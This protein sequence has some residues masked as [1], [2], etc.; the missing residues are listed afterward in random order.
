MEGVEWVLV[1]KDESELYVQCTLDYT[2]RSKGR[3]CWQYTADFRLATGFAS[4]DDVG[5]KVK[6][7]RIPF[8][9]MKLKPYEKA[10]SEWHQRQ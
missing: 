4:Y 6:L 9:T 7:H 5:A 10:A 1:H 8:S 3:P 2:K